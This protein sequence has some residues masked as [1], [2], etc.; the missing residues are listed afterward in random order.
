MELEKHFQMTEKNLI[1]NL[2]A[3]LRCMQ[4]IDFTD[5]T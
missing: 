2:D 5:D 3:C 1:W 4:W